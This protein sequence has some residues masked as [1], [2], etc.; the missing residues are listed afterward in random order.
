MESTIYNLYVLGVML[1]KGLR[2]LIGRNTDESTDGIQMAWIESHQ[3]LGRH[4]KLLRLASELRIHKAQAVGHLKYLWWWAL[5]YAPMGDLSAFASA[6]ISSAA[7]W[8]GNVNS[9]HVA[10]KKTGWLDDDGKIHDWDQYAGPWLSSLERQKRYRDKLRNSGITETANQT[11]PNPTVPNQTN[12]TLSPALPDEAVK[13]AEKLWGLILSNN[14][15]AKQPDNL[16]S[17][18]KEFD[19]MIR[20]DSRTVPDIEAVMVWSQKDA[21][22]RTNILSAGKLRKQFDQLHMKMNAP[23]GGQ[24]GKQGNGF[25]NSGD[26]GDVVIL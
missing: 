14:P 17:W 4:P 15:K 25:R 13:L 11:K 3:S 12:K 20:S 8:P 18:A 26:V 7:E 24:N 10:L 23:R 19:L 6:E 2:T 16:N 22:W 9:F 21:F 1:G 5:D